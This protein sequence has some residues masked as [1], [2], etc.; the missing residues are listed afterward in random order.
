MIQRS[1]S[2]RN[3][4]DLAKI[5]ESTRQLRKITTGMCSEMRSTP[6]GYLV[7]A[8]ATARYI[9]TFLKVTNEKQQNHSILTTPK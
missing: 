6:V 1:C 7:V 2:L 8:V 4:G 3:T 9:K 5:S